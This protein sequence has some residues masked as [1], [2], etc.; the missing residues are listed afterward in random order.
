[1][2]NNSPE[3]MPVLNRSVDEIRARAKLE[4]GKS[5]ILHTEFDPAGDQPA[6]IAELTGGI[7]EGD[8]NQVLLGATGTGKTFTMA[9]VIE[10]TQR[11]AII[12]AP[13]KTLAAQ[14]YGEFKG[15]FPENAVEYFVSYYDYYQPEA[16]VARSDTYIEKESQINEQID[17][18]RHSAT[19]ALLERD[20]VIIV[21]SV[22]CI[23]G[24]GSVETYG[25]MTQDLISGTEYDQRKVMADLIAQQYR[26][27]DAAFQRGSFRVRGDSLE[28]WPA[29]LDDRAWKLSFFGEEL[30]SITEFDPLTGEKT[31]TFEKVRIYANSHYVTPRPTMQQAIKGI[32]SELQ[33]RLDQ[34]VGDGKL[35]E[36]QRLEQRTNFDLEMLEATGV[37]NGI[38]N[39]SRYLTGRAPGE[40][41][42][43]LFEYI[44]DNA[45]VF[46][47]ESHVSV[48]QIGGMYRGDYRRKFTL[49]EHGFRLPSCMDNRPLKFEEWDAMRPQSVFVSATPQSWE[50]DQSGGVFTEQ[51]IRPTGLL[52]P[53]VEI[54]PVGMQVDDLLDEVRRVTADGFRTLVTTLTKRMAE[55]L[56][57]YMHEQGIKVRYMHSD[58]DTLERIEI[59][60]DL[61]L[62]AFDVLIGINLLRE[63]LDIPEC[64]LVAILD[65]DK[66]GFLRSETSLVQTIGRAARNAEGRVIMYADRITGSMER[67]MRETDRRRAKQIAYNT[68]NGITPETVKK[69]VEDILAGLYK[70][71]VDMNRV[72]AK[73][74]KPLHGANLEAVLNGLRAD[75]RKAAENLEFE[76]AARLRDEVK[77]LETVDM[78]VSDDPLARQTAVDQAVS[79]ANKM[80]GRSTAGR[81]GQR[82]GKP[83]RKKGR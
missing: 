82:A 11:P 10:E 53:M 54:R 16:Y 71:D 20:D 17:R 13:N 45:I 30:E 28:I 8:Q 58:I 15:F 83:R 75:M 52:D 7:R 33:T 65:A 12:L 74:E 29:H 4:G 57:E 68:E 36:A 78:V 51:V 50:L 32:K 62:G 61:R 76:E 72:T 39:Y 60:R 38:E 21:A 47:D 34:L 22:S 56:S 48:P 19:R 55:D 64:G 69:N 9:K 1:M 79:T 77:R 6:A 70:G 5:F 24:I 59:L 42:P 25:A 73:V 80:S 81:P 27:N 18:M 43:T 3:Q 67:A 49:A 46:A 23:Y 44:P 40:P 37:C 66:E 26:R 2:H 41:P 31:D 63:G 14:L 35:L